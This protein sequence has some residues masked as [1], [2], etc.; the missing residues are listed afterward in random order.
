MNKN[1]SRLP[2][3]KYSLFISL[4]QRSRSWQEAAKWYQ[5]AIE[6]TEE[7]EEPENTLIS[8]PNYLL[9]AKQ[10]ELYRQGGW[11]LEKEPS[12]AG[13]LYSSAGDL[14]MASMKG[15][16]ANKYYA[17]AEECWAECED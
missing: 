4:K 9:Y 10:A 5:N 15:K 1:R 3:T 17:L 6:V 11:E 12:Y 2:N 14:A 7:D 16:L 8:D 13:E